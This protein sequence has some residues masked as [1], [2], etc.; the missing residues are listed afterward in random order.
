MAFPLLSLAVR[1]GIPAARAGLRFLSKLR[2]P[3]SVT[4][5]RG[6]SV[7]PT[8]SLFEAQKEMGAG[9][10]RWF[11]DDPRLAMKFAGRGTYSWRPSYWPQMLKTGETGYRKGV[12][13][14]LK[15]SKMEA[16][17]GRRLEA[18]LSG[19]K[20]MQPAGDYRYIIVPKSALP[21]VEKDAILTAVANLRKMLGMYNKGGPARILEV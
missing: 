5:Y 14:K 7:I 6:E 8:K 17:L 3:K 4:V 16:E 10:G 1:A 19:S 13:K 9:V 21:R 20:V 18:T 2:Q 11:S 15:L 12:I